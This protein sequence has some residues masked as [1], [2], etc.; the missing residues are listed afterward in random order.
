MNYGPGKLRTDQD[1]GK[2]FIYQ[3]AI[4]PVTGTRNC[5]ST[6]DPRISSQILSCD[7]NNRIPIIMAPQSI[8]RPYSGPDW[9]PFKKR[10]RRVVAMSRVRQFVR[11]QQ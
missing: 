5:S 4:G 11:E 8:R 7:T 10:R 9:I 3:T 6:L 1:T 2:K